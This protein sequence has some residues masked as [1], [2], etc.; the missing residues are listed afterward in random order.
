MAKKKT[1]KAEE[2]TIEQM[3]AQV[4]DLNREIFHLR[5]ELATQK[6]L[7]KPHLIRK[8]RKE[9]ARILTTVTRKQK[10]AV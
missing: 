1:K 7:E 8:K 5:N 6:K 3:H 9:I 10:E 2:Q 4:Y